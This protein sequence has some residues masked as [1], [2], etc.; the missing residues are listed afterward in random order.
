VETWA[1]KYDKAVECLTKDRDA[2]LVFYDFLAEH[3]K[4]LRHRKFVCDRASPHRALEGVSLEQD[5]PVAQN[6]SRRK[7][8]R[9]K[10]S[11]QIASS[12]RCRLTLDLAAI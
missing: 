8:C 5:R 1:V 3:W 7:V 4:H 2:L 12:T 6:H 10:R 11:C 9:R